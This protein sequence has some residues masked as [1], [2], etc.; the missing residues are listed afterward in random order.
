MVAQVLDM[1]QV[2]AQQV[3]LLAQVLLALVEQV[4]AV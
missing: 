4:L 2:V 3:S 1:V